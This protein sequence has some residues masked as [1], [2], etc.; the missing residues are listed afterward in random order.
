MF[1]SRCLKDATKFQTLGEDNAMNLSIT[2]CNFL[3]FR[4]SINHYPSLF[5]KCSK[6]KVL[7]A[8]N[9]MVDVVPLLCKT[10]PPQLGNNLINNFFKVTFRH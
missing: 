3:P 8:T 2:W 7:L 9:V 10:P 1:H 5:N 6:R 4:T